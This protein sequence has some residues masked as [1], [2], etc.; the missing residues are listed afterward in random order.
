MEEE[1]EKKKGKK[2][3]LVKDMKKFY[4]DELKIKHRWNFVI[5]LFIYF[6]LLVSFKTGALSFEKISDMTINSVDVY[7]EASPYENDIYIYSN[8]DINEKGDISTD[9][10]NMNKKQPTRIDAIKQQLT[11]A[12][13]TVISGITPFINIPVLVTAV[14]PL[15]YAYYVA[16]F[17]TLETI[18]MSV[19]AIIEI[20][21]VTLLVAVGMYFCKMSTNHFRYNESSSFTFNDVRLQF[22][23]AMKKNEKVEEIKKKMDKRYEKIKKLNAKTNYKAIIEFSILATVLLCIFTLITGV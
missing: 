9:P 4:N 14:Y 12:A 16:S 19:M 1:K 21:L 23:E 3:N 11:L 6:A 13:I 8:G 5:G 22:N 2:N 17:G 18:L 15:S 7:E 10:L 20:F